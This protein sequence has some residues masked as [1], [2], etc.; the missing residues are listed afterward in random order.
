M[1]TEDGA[2]RWTLGGQ[3]CY[4]RERRRLTQQQLAAQ[5]GISEDA[6]KSVEQGRRPNPCFFTSVKI[7]AA[8]EVSLDQLLTD[9]L[10]LDW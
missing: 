6:V 7:A 9:P 4:W 5:A 2:K 3:I 10:P 8:L 1:T